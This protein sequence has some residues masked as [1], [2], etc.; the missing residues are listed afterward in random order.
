MSNI[1]HQL[2]SRS[3]ETYNTDLPEDVKHEAKRAILNILGCGIG[4]SQHPAVDSCISALQPYS[5]K[6]GSRA[7]GRR[8]ILDPLLAS[9][10]NGISTHVHDYDDTTPHNYIHNSSPVAA[11]LFAYASTN[12]VAGPQF[13]RAFA[14]GF[15]VSSR[16]GNATYPAH[17]SA[18]WHST[19]SI[20]VFGAV[21]AIGLLQ[22]LSCSQ[23]SHAIGLAATQSAGLRAMFGSMAKSFHPGRAAQNGYVAALLAQHGFTAGKDSLEGPRGF[24]AV[25]AGS[26]NLDKV[27]IRFGEDFDILNNTYKPYPCGIVVHPTLDA[28]I[29][30]YRDYQFNSSDIKEI[31]L[32]VA[33]IVKDLCNKT[34]V[35][36]GLDSKFSVY[37]AAA[38]SL[39]TGK[40]GLSEFTDETAK[41]PTIAQVRQRVIALPQSTI[42]D[43]SVEVEVYLKDGRILRNVVQH[44]KGHLLNPLTDRELEQK[45]LDQSTTLTNKNARDLLRVCWNIE[46]LANVGDLV[47]ITVA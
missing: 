3:L 1:T 27:I 40:A 7:I 20:G 5:A 2:A 13:L 47:A 18:G 44:A 45:F 36:S 24:A 8:E 46:E 6:N 31:R 37:H 9:L 43:D 28:C 35:Q 17:Y 25:E 39:V 32:R 19:G 38:V 29:Q 34:D 41:N 15:E 42:N 21:I 22:K 12:P 11:A 4:G 23:L 26:Y 16:I 14:I 10:V 33:P 30:I